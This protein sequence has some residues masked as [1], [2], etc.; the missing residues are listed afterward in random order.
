MSPVKTLCCNLHTGYEMVFHARLPDTEIVSRGRNSRRS[1][2]KKQQEGFHMPNTGKRL[3]A[4]Y[5]AVRAY[6]MSM[7]LIFPFF[8]TDHYFSILSDR[9]RYYK[10]STLILVCVMAAAAAVTRMKDTERK[11][12]IGMEKKTAI[13]LLA[14]FTITALVSAGNSEWKTLAFDGSAGRLQGAGMW[15]LYFMSFLLIALS[16]VPS[17][18]DFCLFLLGGGIVCLWGIAN[19]IGSDW[20]GWHEGMKDAQKGMFLSSIG[21][22]NTF[23][24]MASIYFAVSGTAAVMDHDRKL[25]VRLFCAAVFL[26]SG[27]ALFIGMSDNSAIAVLAFFA[28]IPFAALGERKTS[29]NCFTAAALFT[30][31]MGL[32]AWINHIST[33]PFVNRQGSILLK[34]CRYDRISWYM[35][36]AAFLLAAGLLIGNRKRG[37]SRRLLTV[38]TVAFAVCALGAVG[39]FLDANFGGTP[40]KYGSFAKYLVFNDHWGT[41]RGMVWRL[42]WESFREFPPVQKFIGC[43]PDTFGLVMKRDCYEEM[44]SISGQFYDSPHNELIQHIVCTGFLGAAAYYGFLACCFVNGFRR[45]GLYQSA[46]MGILV[47]TAVSFVNISVPITQPFIIIL[48]GVCLAGSQVG[49]GK[50]KVQAESEQKTKF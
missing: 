10:V 39:V 37:W 40:D 18:F 24:A 8:A 38:Y 45:G 1:K 21:N 7:F 16:Y 28:V 42:A 50:N 43:G 29:G 26:V 49:A 12:K 31:M 34:L 36:A 25:P 5:A 3:N 17:E 14:L 20:F 48:A 11:E 6:L 32:T 30:G 2:R 27:T 15:C 41:T 22:I 46:A 13:L 35:A 33:N 19:Y 23:T 47:Y 9:A 44:V 4:A